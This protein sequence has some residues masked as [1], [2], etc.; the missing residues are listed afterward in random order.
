MSSPKN[1]EAEATALLSRLKLGKNLPIRV[2]SVAQVLGVDI[3]YEPFSED[4]SGILV[5]EPSR[6]VI[7]VNS[8]HAITRQRFTIAHELGHF[9]LGHKGDLFIDKT[10]RSPAVV[11]RRDGKSSLGTD[12][13]EI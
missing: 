1:P 3:K 4:L 8:S 9:I 12:A 2:E 10:L 6:T 11:V 7:G 13:E 5:K